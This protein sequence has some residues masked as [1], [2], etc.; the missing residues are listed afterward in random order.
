MERSFQDPLASGDKEPSY[1]RCWL[2]FCL[3]IPSED[4][5]YVIYVQL[6]LSVSIAMM[7]I[8]IVCLGVIFMFLG[9]AVCFV[10]LYI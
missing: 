5:W 3:S 4:A 9:G 2:Q 7:R 1:N 6:Y 8:T 10:L